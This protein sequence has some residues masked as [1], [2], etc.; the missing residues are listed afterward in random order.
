MTT[1]TGTDLITDALV[2]IGAY[3]AGDPVSAA[4]LATGLRYLNRLID[5]SNAEKATIFTAQLDTLTMTPNN[6]PEPNSLAL[7]GTAV[8]TVGLIQRRRRSR[9][10]LAK[11]SWH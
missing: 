8:L 10:G 7:L 11:K 3:A 5:S 4:D 2:E 6:V 9:D 1:Q